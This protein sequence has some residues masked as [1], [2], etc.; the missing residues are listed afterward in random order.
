MAMAIVLKSREELALVREAGRVVAEVLQVLAEAARPGVRERKLNE[1]VRREFARRHVKPTFLGY[2]GYPACVCV[3]VNDEIVHGIPGDRPFQ[4]GDIV[5]VDL[6]ATYKGYVADAAITIG[7]GQ[8]T[9]EAQRLIDVTRE[10]LC[11]GIAAART[12]ARVGAISWAIQS[13]VET[14]GFSVVR[15]YVGHGVGR[16]M[17]EEPQVPNFGSPDHGIVLRQGMVLAIE[18]MV[19]AG[20]WRTRR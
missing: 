16:Q 2:Y 10:A 17:H 15:E 13:Y 3:S 11:R 6:G 20:D 14:N 18:P 19:N 1:I 12:G 9:P 5:S 8:I 4:E 7:V